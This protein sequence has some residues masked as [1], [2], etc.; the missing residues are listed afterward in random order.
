MCVRARVCVGGWV[1]HACV[2]ARGCCVTYPRK[3]CVRA[4]LLRHLGAVLPLLGEVG[5]DLDGVPKVDR[6]RAEGEREA[7]RRGE[8]DTV[9]PH[10]CFSLSFPL[11]QVGQ[12]TTTPAG[13]GSCMGKSG[14][15]E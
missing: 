9:L 15:F 12:H 6:H 10:P 4:W 2:R 5:P 14:G 1:L 3:P 13:H 11:P 7:L 8:G